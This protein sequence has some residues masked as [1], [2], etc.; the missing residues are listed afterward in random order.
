[1]LQKKGMLREHALLARYLEIRC[2]KI[3]KEAKNLNLIDQLKVLNKH[4]QDNVVI[5]V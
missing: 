4:P 1:M 5:N 2:G 3:T